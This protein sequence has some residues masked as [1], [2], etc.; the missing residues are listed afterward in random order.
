MSPS[1]PSSLHE[2]EIRRRH[3]YR[4]LRLDEGAL[5][6]LRSMIIT[7]KKLIRTSAGLNQIIVHDSQHSEILVVRI[8]ILREREM[9]A[10]L[11]P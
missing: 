6:N 10:T 1:F 5:R 7:G 4:S 9:K 11:Q 2:R 3:M 8:R